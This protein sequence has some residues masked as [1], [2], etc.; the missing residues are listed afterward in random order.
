MGLNGTEAELLPALVVGRGLWRIGTRAFLVQHNLTASELALFD[1]DAPHARRRHVRGRR[2]LNPRGMTDEIADL[3]VLLLVAAIGISG[4]LWLAAWLTAAITAEP[5]PSAGVLEGA[6][7][8]LAD[9]ADPGAA[10]RTPIG[11]I[12][13][14]LMTG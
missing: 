8:L 5:Q 6:A 3:V 4:A 10:W 12:A 7:A 2:A 9:P 13:Y 14:W 1:T 11:P